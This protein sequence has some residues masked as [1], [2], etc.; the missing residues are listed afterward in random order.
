MVG[1]VT[2]KRA[3]ISPAYLILKEIALVG[4]KSFSVKE[5]DCVLDLVAVG[6][7]HARVDTTV[8]LAE[9]RA[10]HERMESGENLG[11]VVLE[12]AGERR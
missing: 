8:P 3:A 11:R 6:A 5:M 10:V 9:C 1:N 7:V 12:V 4:T 2:G